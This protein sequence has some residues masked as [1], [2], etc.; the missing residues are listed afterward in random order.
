MLWYL[1]VGGQWRNLPEGYPLY[2]SVFYYFKRW[3]LNGTLEKLNANLNRQERQRQGKEETPS[4]LSI[5][6]QSIKAAPFV[7]EKR[8][9]DG[10]KHINGRQRHVLT[11]TLGLV[12]AVVVHAAHQADGP[13]VE[14]VVAPL[15]GYLCRMKKILADAAYKHAF[16]GWVYANLLGVELEISSRPP[17]E[18]GFVP[19]RCRW[20]TERT[21][22]TFNRP[23]TFRLAEKVL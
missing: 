7:Q 12:W 10:N 16:V 3:K 9:I 11:D 21:F 13:T 23:A 22:G 15:Q 1:R 20:V 17:T 4:L 14:R 8:G 2:A 6:T 18:E 19:I 5:D